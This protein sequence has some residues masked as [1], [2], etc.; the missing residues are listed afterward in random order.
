MNEA[1]ALPLP[2]LNV[3]GLL[4]RM[5]LSLVSGVMQAGTKVTLR[6]R[7]GREGKGQA[8]GQAVSLGPRG[9]RARAHGEV[10]L[11]LEMGEP[12]GGW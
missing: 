7:H 10:C 12:A 5:R 8:A 2:S 9:C 1:T 11:D 3:K 6:D 4:R